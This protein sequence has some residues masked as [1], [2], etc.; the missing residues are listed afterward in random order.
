MQQFVHSSGRARVRFLCVLYTREWVRSVDR[1]GLLHVNTSSF[2]FFQA[3]EV[4]TQAFL[5]YNLCN[6]C[7]STDNLKQK[8]TEDE[9]VRFYWAM[10][11]VDILDEAAAT[12]LLQSIVKL[13]IRV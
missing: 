6:P 3:L 8:V 5:H 12:E 2:L 4:A 7:S 1:G 10:V 11:S 13:W 9:D